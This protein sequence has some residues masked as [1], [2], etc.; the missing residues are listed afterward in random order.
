ML[1]SMTGFG[2]GQ[3]TGDGLSLS[4][5]IKSVNQRFC[6]ISVKAPRLLAPFEAQLKKRVG[7]KVNRG[8]V[9]LFINIDAGETCALEARINRPLAKA[10]VDALQELKRDF[11]VSGE[12]S[13]EFLAA[14]KDLLLIREAELDQQLLQDC[15]FSALELALDGLESMR[16]AEGRATEAD[17]KSRCRQ[18]TVLAGQIEKLAPEVVVEWRQKLEQRLEKISQEL[19]VDPQRVA[20]EVAIFADRCDISEELIRFRSHLDQFAL[21]FEADEPVGRKMDFLVQELNRETNTMGSKSNHPELTRLVVELKA[22][23]E[24]IREQVQNIE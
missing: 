11:P 18:L 8:K 21:L 9:D 3:A 13:L 12:I 23:L 7:E 17:L 5:E 6:D 19:T 15:L 20:Q 4:V 22:E 1:K 14:Q 10:Y 16:S 24:K 2:K